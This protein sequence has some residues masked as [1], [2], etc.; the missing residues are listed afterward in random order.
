MIA[1]AGAAIKQGSF[2]ASG[3]SSRSATGTR[4]SMYASTASNR[5]MR[6]L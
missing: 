3:Y 4:D 6:M 2:P 5:R 1:G